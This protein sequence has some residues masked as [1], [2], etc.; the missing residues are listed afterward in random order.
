M[1]FGNFPTPTSNPFR[2]I[3]L[4][5]Q[6]HWKGFHLALRAL[7]EFQ[8]R[9][10]DSEYWLV[11]DGPESSRLK[12]L[13][14]QLG[15]QHKVAFWGTLPKLADVYDKL[16]EC[17]VLVHPALHEAFGNVCLEAMA[18][19]RPVV[20]LDLGGPAL[21]VTEDTGIK[22]PATSP[23]Q[24]IHDLASAFYKLASDPGLRARLS[25]GARKRVEE[26]FDWE[27]KGLFMTKLYASLSTLAG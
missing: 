20:C 23:E 8:L 19:D 5:K 10:P 18:A 26:H 25:L 3:R 6:I 4:G 13:A 27:Q 15:V 17:D 11:N 16:R 7:A 21:Q 9:C 14:R 24:V 22:V 1:Y 2:L 12:R